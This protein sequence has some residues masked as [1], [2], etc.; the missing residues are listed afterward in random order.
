MAEDLSPCIGT[1][2]KKDAICVGDENE[3]PCGWRARCRA[4]TRYLKKTKKEP[5]LYVHTKT[6]VKDGEEDTVGFARHGH[7]KFCGFCD[8]LIEAERKKKEP[9]PP[10][11]MR[12]KGPKPATIKASKVAKARVAKE[13][14]SRLMDEFR[15]FQ[16]ALSVEVGREFG[17][18]GNIVLPGELYAVDR[19]DNVTSGYVAIYCRSAVGRDSALI[20]L[21]LRPRFQTF[22][23]RLRV[24]VDQM[25][26]TLSKKNMERLDPKEINVGLFKSEIRGVGRKELALMAEIISG[27]VEQGIIVLP[28]A[29]R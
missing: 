20:R 8:K 14:R 24:K 29:K 15:T 3:P 26:Q 9:P 13:N 28:D 11:D 16:K 6:V 17:T 21:K 7:E 18:A 2:D 12:K 19:T 25:K 5:D 10:M 22:D 23:A 27:W 1:Y 4:F